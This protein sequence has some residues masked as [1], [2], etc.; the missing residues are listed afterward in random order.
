MCNYAFQ[1]VII[2]YA[3]PSSFINQI[4]FVVTFA[5]GKRAGA[6]ITSLISIFDKLVLIHKPRWYI[7]HVK[8]ATYLLSI[9][10]GIVYE[11]N[12]VYNYRQV[13]IIQ[14]PFDD[15]KNVHTPA[16]AASTDVY[17]YARVHVMCI[18]I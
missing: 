17:V 12:G 7:I 15:K 2:S 9:Q 6:W 13:A 10:V 14:I 16:L 4:S 8:Q 1:N 3:K 11:S 18:I 5:N